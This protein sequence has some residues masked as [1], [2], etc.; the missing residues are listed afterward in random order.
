MFT[1]EEISTILGEHTMS[2]DTNKKELF[3]WLWKKDQKFTAEEVQ[4]LLEQVKA[5]NCGAIDDYLSKHVDK[6]FVEWL[7]AK[8]K[9]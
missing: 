8:N 4:E 1:Q 3:D 5:F 9:K 6:T 7:E 2:K